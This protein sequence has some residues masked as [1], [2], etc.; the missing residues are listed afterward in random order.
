MLGVDD[1]DLRRMRDALFFEG[2][3][4]RH[5]LTRFW[6][7]L[8]L[9]AVIA[10][11]G[12]VSDSTATVIGAMIV[13]PLMTPILGIVLAT[14]LGDRKNLLRSILLVIA[15][16]VAVIAIAWLLGMLSPVDAVAPGNSQVAGRISP[17]TVDLVAAL[18]TG[19]V[20][21]FA[22]VRSDVSDT[23]PGV[24]IA[25][26][27]VPPLAVVGLTLEAGRPDQARGALLLFLTNVAAIL[28]TGV[29]VMAMYRVRRTALANPPPPGTRTLSNRY[30]VAVIVVF[31]A[32]IAVPLV[33]SGRRYSKSTLT[34]DHVA[35]IAERWAKPAD[36][37][38]V[39][40]EYRDGKVV[41]RAA[42]PN[43]AP[44]PAR[45]RAL[46]DADREK[47]T[48]VSLELVPEQRVDLPSK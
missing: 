19:A 25:I 29:I 24:A 37:E 16:A 12:V 30:P 20:G 9:A 6:A 22:L 4:A 17:R 31:V 8:V 48:E 44:D 36:W 39:S 46:L 40:A 32:V 28:L 23:L 47:G 27:L 13:A 3:E 2:E 43:P 26:S 42:G 38:I 15:G 1:A 33:A 14:G 41:V 18:A 10:T 21:A 5:R 34:A 11:A 7:L 45:L 35:S